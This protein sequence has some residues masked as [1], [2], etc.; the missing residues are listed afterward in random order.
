MKNYKTHIH[1]IFVILIVSLLTILTELV[2]GKSNIRNENIFLLFVLSVII[3]LIET[4]KVWYGVIE[5]A[6]LILSFNFFLTE[7]YYTFVVNDTNYII[8]FIIFFVVSLIVGSLVSKLQKQILISEKNEK[9]I[10][11]MYDFSKR[12]LNAHKASEIYP[13]VIN[14]IK[15]NLNEDVYVVSENYEVYGQLEVNDWLKDAINYSLR[16]NIRVGKNEE[17]YSNLDYM[18]FPIKSKLYTFGVLIVSCKNNLN[19]DDIDFIHNIVNEL[20]IILDREK[21]IVEQELTK[22]KIATEKFKTSLLRSLSHD[23]KTPL[24]TIQSGSR[25]IVDSYDMLDEKTKKELIEEIYDESLSLNEFV[26]NLLNMSKLDETKSIGNARVESIDDIIA[27]TKLRLEKFRYK[28]S[29]VYNIP[30]EILMVYTNI[31]LLV[32]VLINLID[33]AIKHTKED[34]SIEV[35]VKDENS[36]VRFSVN[37]NGGGIDE[38]IINNIFEDFYSLRTK[39][40]YHRST[41]LGLSICKS[42][43]EA[44]G[45]K[46]HCFNN[47]QNG[48]TFTFIIPKDK[49]K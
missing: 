44:H 12:F 2:I 5:S 20:I 47:S 24:T 41:G 16:K 11:T 40:D 9:N 4:K 18:V 46:I 15:N 31:D 35:S 39:E 29:I 14:Y 23:I 22:E 49:I 36:Y 19:L 10:K 6:I 42:I 34:T 25:F 3:T 13:I 26:I 45:G 7:P 27:M 1:D 48:A 43:V 17:K 21:I 28:K 30:N 37:D 32:Q 38:S 8:M 33:N